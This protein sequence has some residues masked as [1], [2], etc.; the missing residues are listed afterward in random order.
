MEK[1][2]FTIDIEDWF[3]VENLK[4]CI[5]GQWSDKEIRV[6]VN[7]YKLLE[8]L[9]M[10]EVKAT[11]FVLGWIAERC[12]QLVMDISA[13]GHEVACHG[14]GHQLVYE[15]NPKEFRDD[16]KK[17]KALLEGLIGKKIVGYRAPSFSITEWA[18]DILAEEGFLYDSS[19]FAFGGNRY[20][21]L[22][23]SKAEKDKTKD[24]YKLPNGLYE[25]PATT[26]TLFGREL[27]WGGG[28]YFRLLPYSIFEW[29]YR[30]AIKQKGS[31]MFYLHPWEIDASQP[32]VEGLK[33]SYAF[34]HYNG[35]DKTY[36]KLDGFIKQ[37]KHC[38]SK[39]Y[40]DKIQGE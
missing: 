16:I 31:G 19:Y 8:I 17:S 4:E 2:F 18:V 1:I 39:I 21:K 28:G 40:F 12:P 6:E 7:T 9:D 14:Y 23:L 32:R 33:R 25:Y 10:Y 15:Q 29:G 35:L 5:N 38:I 34:R 26:L 24:I 13:K 11:F 3:Q 30:K 27:P 20:G 37:S 36:K 22:D